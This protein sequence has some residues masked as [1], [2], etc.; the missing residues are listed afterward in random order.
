MAEDFGY[1]ER[2]SNPTNSCKVVEFASCN[3]EDGKGV[4]WKP[5]MSDDILKAGNRKV[6]RR[7]PTEM[8]WKLVQWWREIYDL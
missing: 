1:P 5:W 3:R 7:L 8:F 6:C 4:R 2:I